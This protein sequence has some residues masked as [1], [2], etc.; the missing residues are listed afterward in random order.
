MNRL[1]CV[2][3]MMACVLASC[4]KIELGEQTVTTAY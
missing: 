3:A 4:Q 2:A 1:F